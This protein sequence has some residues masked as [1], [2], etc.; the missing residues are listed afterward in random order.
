MAVNAIHSIVERR[1]RVVDGEGRRF[2]FPTF[3]S[4]RHGMPA[5]THTDRV[6]G[7][8]EVTRDLSDQILARDWGWA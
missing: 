6:R 1:V 7:E 4:L 2:G 3:R 5:A 8:A